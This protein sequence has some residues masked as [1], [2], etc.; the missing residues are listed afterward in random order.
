MSLLL[1]RNRVNMYASTWICTKESSTVR[2]D[3]KVSLR[4]SS[5]GELMIGEPAMDAES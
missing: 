1:M 2:D 5:M 4:K 3:P